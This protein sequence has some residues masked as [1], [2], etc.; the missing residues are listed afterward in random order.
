MKLIHFVVLGTFLF[1]SG[2]VASS[3]NT[4]GIT[5]TSVDNSAVSPVEV[6][7]SGCLENEESHD[8]AESEFWK[9]NSGGFDIRWTSRDLYVAG[10]DGAQRIFSDY[11]R[12]WA[13]PLLDDQRSGKQKV[14]DCI[15]F[16]V[17][18]IVGS[19][20]SIE[21]DEAIIV[22]GSGPRDDMK[23]WIVIDLSKPGSVSQSYE[24]GGAG[25]KDVDIT[26]LFEKETVA[27]ALLSNEVIK[28]RIRETNRSPEKNPL[29]GGDPLWLDS[30]GS[31]QL[32]GF[33]F[34]KFAFVDTSGADVSIELEVLQTFDTHV[35]KVESLGISLP[36]LKTVL[37][38][39]TMDAKAGV[40]GFLLNTRGE[41]LANAHTSFVFQS[42]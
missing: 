41:K 36:L 39:E 24:E 9:G 26:E 14:S 7:T 30:N 34:N 4:G 6:T 37:S 23:S 22:T 11:A 42:K 19:L 18:S 16:N 20:V 8:K 13:K 17:L 5:R 3:G 29:V 27:D 33:S 15:S 2:C 12:T 40:H 10:K 38:S 28:R 35:I 21:V 25:T 32:N 31:K 1:P